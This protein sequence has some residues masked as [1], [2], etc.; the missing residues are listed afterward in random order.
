M[1]LPTSGALAFSNI[2][3]EFGGANPIALS[4][5]YAGGAYVPAGTSGTNG[6][7]PASGAIS[8]SKFYGTSQTVVNFNDVTVYAIVIGG[9]ASASYK[10]D[11]NGS[12]YRGDGGVYTVNSQ[13][14]TPAAQGGNY[15]VYASIVSGTLTSGTTGSWVATSGS[16][17][18]VK[19]RIFNGVDSVSLS[20]QV[21]RAGYTTVLD[22]WNVSLTA[23]NG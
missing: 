12:D 6:A 2:Q 11:T 19:T 21:R 5:Y 9:P 10:V 8:V 23:E 22:T 18:W 7:V 14:V 20:M 1:T 17:L 4:E 3:T 16:P 15:E 13:W